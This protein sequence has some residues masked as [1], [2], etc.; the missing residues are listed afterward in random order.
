MKTPQ[1]RTRSSTHNTHTHTHAHTHTNTHTH[2]HTRV[3]TTAQMHT[4]HTQVK[5]EISVR[6]CRLHFPR[7]TT[8]LW[9]PHAHTHVPK[10]NKQA[11]NK[12][13]HNP[14]QTQTPHII[15]HP[16]HTCTRKHTLLIAYEIVSICCTKC[17]VKGLCE[18]LREIV[19]T[20]IPHM[21]TCENTEAHTY[22]HT[23]T[24]KHTH[25]H[26]H[27]HTNAHARTHL[28]TH[29]VRQHA[30]THTCC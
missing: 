10:T 16:K 15:A 13:V 2:T 9:N 24:L 5:V 19:Q 22:A 27:M 23:H 30:L 26:A 25:T 6:N 12:H 11:N 21:H 1:T 4:Q 28:H 8:P 20:R 7:W 29:N 3:H 18:S 17:V 14:T